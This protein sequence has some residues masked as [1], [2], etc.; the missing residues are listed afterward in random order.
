[1]DR[2]YFAVFDGHGGVDAARYAAVHVH[3]NAARQPKL[4]TDP[5]EALKEAFQHTDE[6]FLWKAKREVRTS[7]QVSRAVRGPVASRIGG[8][9]STKGRIPKWL[10]AKEC[11]HWDGL[12]SCHLLLRKR[13]H[14]FI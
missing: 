5:A 13:T 9:T 6:M 2:A 8:P 10:M 11:P 14:F 7:N 4:L 12:S 1:M 3:V